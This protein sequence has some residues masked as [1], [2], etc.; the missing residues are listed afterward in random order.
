MDTPSATTINERAR[1]E[2]GHWV[3]RF[4]DDPAVVRSAN[5]VR[6]YRHDLTRWIDFCR[7][8]ATNP[9][10]VR[11]SDVIAFIRHER[12]RSIGDDAT[13]S[14]RTI[15]RRLSA[16][17]QWYGF[18]MVEPELTGVHRNPVPAGSA[19]RTASGIAAGQ[20]AL[21]RYDCPH[22]QI[23]TPEEIDRFISHLT[24]DRDRAIVWLLKDGGL[25]VGEAL[26]LRL[27]DIHWAERRI[28]VRATKTHTTRTIALSAEALRAVSAYVREERPPALE[29]DHL[30]VCLGRRSFGQPLRYRAWVAVCEQARRRAETPRVHAHAFRHTCATN[31]AEAGMPLDALQRQLGHRHLDTTMVYNEIR[32]GR[33]QREYRQAMERQ[34]TG[35]QRG[36]E[37]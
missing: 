34:E 4:L 6:A 23:L 7:A 36:G 13:V 25:R 28:T 17:R 18:L 37:V 26:D 31:L 30:F 22:P 9:L 35:R 11:P 8:T 32:D 27:G 19:V 2:A 29:H 1:E 16:I 20:P 14:A 33:L 10:R 3:Q 24:S 21:L 5:T 12:E 15:V